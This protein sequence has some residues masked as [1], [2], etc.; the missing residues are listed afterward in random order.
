[1]PAPNPAPSRPVTLPAPD[2]AHAPE[3]DQALRVRFHEGDPAA[4]EAIAERFVGDVWRFA[5]TIVGDADLAA[6]AVQETFLRVLER[7]R[8]YSPERAFRPWLFAV[9]RNCCRTLLRERDAAAARVVDLDPSAEEVERLA[10]E[11]PKAFEEQLRMERER[12]ALDALASIPEARRTVVLLHLFED[13]PFREIAE[14]VGVPQNTAATWYYRTLAELR[15]RLGAAPR[16][17]RHV[18]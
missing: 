1:M 13:L 2:S 15:E 7:H 5:S 16:R 10:A 18:S 4:V 11:A 6:D 17:S 8:L 14:I 9:C 3:P 12:E